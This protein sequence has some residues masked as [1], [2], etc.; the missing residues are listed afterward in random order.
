MAESELGDKRAPWDGLHR[1]PGL[2]RPRR[3]MSI[4]AAHPLVLASASPR[5]REL[6]ERVGVP[7][8]VRPVDVD[9]TPRPHEEA[10]AYLERVVADKAAAA[11]SAYPEGLLLVA[12]TSVII[13]G[14]V[15]GKPD[16]DDEARVMMERL[17]G[18]GHEV[19]TRFAL[20][21]A[22][23]VVQTVRTRVW[24][25]PLNA[26]QIARYVATGEGSDKAGGY[27]IQGVGAM[28]VAR[29]EG[30]YTNVVG[31]PLAEV[32]VALEA[33]GWKGPCS[34]T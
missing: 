12:D 26:E 20:A 24:F 2:F 23:T 7:L 15:L 4:D 8:I 22:S 30:S 17:Q 6:L 10:H 14:E 11:R 1:G 9:E 16:S 34:R 32:V 5:R 25:R 27:G 33:L 3:P 13:D 18:R 29:V 31:L 19:A 28:L 21:D